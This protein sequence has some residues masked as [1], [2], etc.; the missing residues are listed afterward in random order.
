MTSAEPHI[1]SITVRQSE[2]LLEMM[3]DGA[4][5]RTISRRLGVREETVKSHMRQVLKAARDAGAAADTR[6][7]LIVALF[8]GWLRYQVRN[9]E[10]A[11]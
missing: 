8:R 3:R 2:A 7:E 9:S 11:A 5:T 4:N 10:R 6:E 1:M